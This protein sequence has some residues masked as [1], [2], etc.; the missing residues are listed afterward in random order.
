MNKI[1]FLVFSSAILIFGAISIC[2]AP[3]I[4]K[5]ITE[6]TSWNTDNCKK[7]AD[8][9]NHLKD[10]SGTDAQINEQKKIRNLCNRRKAMYGLEYSSL[11]LDVSLGFIC[12]ILGI[13]HFFNV[14]KSFQKYS[15][16]IGVVTGII[17]FILTL[18]YVCYSGYIFTNDITP[19]YDKN[20]YYPGNLLKLNGD[21]AFAESIE[22]NRYKCIYSKDEDSEA[23]F[24]K[25]SDLGKKQYNYE[26]KRYMNSQ[27]NYCQVPLIDAQ[28]NCDLYK[29]YEFTSTSFSNP[30][31]KQLLL[32]SYPQ[33]IENKY[34]YDRWVTTLIFSCFIIV[35]CI[36]LAIFGFLLFKN[37]N[38]TSK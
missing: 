5:V 4:N 1:L 14:G 38:I 37:S 28:R 35:C 7:N 29:R 27:N 6:S 22:G 17:C 30:P 11:I 32:T 19:N 26:K 3:I 9:Y 34:V 13:L 12:T 18:V 15:G 25:Y 33:G 23:V 2:S 31:C 20:Y 24:A 36:G 16:I 10:N 8:E 21:G